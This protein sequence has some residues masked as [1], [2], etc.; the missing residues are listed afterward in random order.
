MASPPQFDYTVI[1]PTYNRA[2]LIRGC[3]RPFTE[4]SHQGLQVIVVDDGSTDDTVSVVDGIAAASRGA[5]ISL[6]R[7][8]NG[9][10]SAARNTGIRK[11]TTPFVAMLDSD[12]HW[13]PWT[14]HELQAAIR[15]NPQVALILFRAFRF[16]TDDRLPE[17]PADIRR[18][19]LHPSFLHFYL[20]PSIPVYGSCNACVRKE[21]FL[22]VDGFD[23]TIR[24]VEDID[25][26]FRLATAGQTLVIYSPAMM[27]S[28]IDTPGSLSK[29]NEKVL[30]GLL[31]I[32]A[33]HRA[34]QLSGDPDLL[35][36]AVAR[37]ASIGI[38]TLLERGDAHSARQLF[39]AA[40]GTIRRGLGLRTYAGMGFRLWRHRRPG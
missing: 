28:R 39:A 32:Q 31:G 3:L 2:D 12:D 36:R 7:Q 33:K 26:F 17:T 10:A 24:S 38:W 1:I 5:A 20:D 11:A 25:L 21:A 29:D 40:G 18:D 27:A 8:A 37:S 4:P 6:I 35:A 14:A 13:F 34:G 15:A 19:S 16:N 22:G 30:D 9:G 23:T